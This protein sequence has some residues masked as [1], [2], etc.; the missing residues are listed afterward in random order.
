MGNDCCKQHFL[1]QGEISESMRE[2]YEPHSFCLEEEDIEVQNKEFV[3]AAALHVKD[4]DNGNDEPGTK[5]LPEEGENLRFVRDLPVIYQEMFDKLDSKF[6]KWFSSKIDRADDFYVETAP[7][8]VEI[9]NENVIAAK[10]PLNVYKSKLPSI[11]DVML[12][13][14][15]IHAGNLGNIDLLETHDD[16]NETFEF[17]EGE[18]RR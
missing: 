4:L 2:E 7:N 3:L 12:S 9:K 14:A 1:D 17:Y 6:G 8:P 5:H 18:W 10:N 15:N 16:E 11:L 13:K